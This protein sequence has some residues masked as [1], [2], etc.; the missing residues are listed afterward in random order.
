VVPPVFQL[1][2]FHSLEASEF[3]LPQTATL[4]DEQLPVRKECFA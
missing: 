2:L 4:D 3:I 1:V